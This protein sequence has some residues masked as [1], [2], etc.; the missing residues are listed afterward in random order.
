[1]VFTFSMTIALFDLEYSVLSLLQTA[2]TK[3]IPEVTEKDNVGNVTKRDP[4][5]HNA[6]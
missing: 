4:N 6:T 3:S 2:G 5:L 1:M